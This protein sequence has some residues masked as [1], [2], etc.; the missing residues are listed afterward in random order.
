MEKVPKTKREKDG[1]NIESIV[2][3]TRLTLKKNYGRY[4]NF[5]PHFSWESQELFTEIERRL[6]VGIECYY[7][8]NGCPDKSNEYQVYFNS[9]EP[10]YFLDFYIPELRKWI[11]FDEK[12]HKYNYMKDYDTRRERSIIVGVT[13]IELLR[14][15]SDDFTGSKRETV[16]KCLN[17][18]LS[19]EKE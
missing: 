15:S 2:E 13:S 1:E 10:V 18:I 4:S 16:N 9:D 6:P 7:A 19:H 5:F 12:H 3:K 11:E 8:T 14:V 17:F